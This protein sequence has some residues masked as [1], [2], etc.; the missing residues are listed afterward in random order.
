[1]FN[2]P[3]RDLALVDQPLGRLLDRHAD[4]GVVVGRAHDQVDLGQDAP[5]VGRVV[6]GERA[7]RGLDA[8]DALGRRLRS[9]ARGTPCR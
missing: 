6:V 5:L 4:R 2:S 7:A 3:S 9:A 8:A 1:M